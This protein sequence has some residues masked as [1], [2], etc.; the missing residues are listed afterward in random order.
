MVD[1]DLA[2][3]LRSG[4]VFTWDTIVSEADRVKAWGPIDGHLIEVKMN[5][6]RSEII[7]P[8]YALEAVRQYLTLDTDVE[9]IYADLKD[10]G[11]QSAWFKTQL[12][13]LKQDPWT[14]IAS[15]I[16]SQQNNIPRIRTLVQK[17]SY[18]FG[19]RFPRAQGHDFP[20]FHAIAKA[21]EG[22]LRALG[23]GFRAPYLLKTSQKLSEDNW[24]ASGHDMETD[25]LRSKLV[26][27][28]GVG[29]KIADCVL[30]FAYKRWDVCPVDVHIGRIFTKMGLYATD[31][32]E[33]QKWAV[34]KFGQY[35][36]WAQQFLYE[37]AT[38]TQ[39]GD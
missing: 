16:L 20:S 31:P 15:F 32:D 12:R 14:C 28:Q 22:D 37:D 10:H 8:V 26:G 38:N 39:D 35:A 17:L 7:C 4:Q 6:G 21:S 19:S 33:V 1:V 18:T 29:R 11:L 30:L 36:G 2:S 27:F 34:D 25:E 3:T 24:L 23:L 9:A 13:I 5:V